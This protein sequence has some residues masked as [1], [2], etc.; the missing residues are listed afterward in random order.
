M[1]DKEKYTLRTG[2]GLSLECG[3]DEDLIVTLYMF[4]DIILEVVE[5]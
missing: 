1:T 3:K 2:N 5:V 4:P